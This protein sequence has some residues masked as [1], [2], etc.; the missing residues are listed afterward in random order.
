MTSRQ[1]SRSSRRWILVALLV[2]LLCLVLWI[3]AA[4][5]LNIAFAESLPF[6]LG[7]RSR[8]AANYA[9]DEFVGSLGVFRLS[10][11]D[12]VLLDRGIPP[13]EVEEQSEKI[14]E[15]MSLPVPTAT[16]RDF[17]GNEPF[18][19]TPTEPLI[20]SITAIS[21]ETPTPT[22]TLWIFNTATDTKVPPTD[23]PAVPSKTPTF[24]PSPT[25]SSTPSLTPSITPSPTQCYVDPFIV[26][27]DPPN[28][29]ETYVDGQFLPAQAFA[30]DPDN[31]DPVTC[32]PIGVYPSD[33]GV[34]IN[35]VE[36]QIE[37]VDGGGVIVYE[38]TEN[39]PA[40]CGFSGDSPCTT[41]PVSSSNWPFGGDPINAGLHKLMARAEDDGG[42]WSDW[43]YVYFILD[44]APTP[45]PTFTPSNTPTFTPT[46]TD[47]STP[48]PTHTPTNTPTF[49]PPPT[50]TPTPTP[51]STP[52]PTFT[53]SPTYTETQ[54]PTPT[55][56]PTATSTPTLTTCTAGTV[57][58]PSSGD[59]WI[60]GT[61]SGTNHGF[62]SNLHVRPT[63]GSDHRTLIQFELTAIPSTCTT[64]TNATLRI[65]QKDDYDQ[66][67]EVFRIVQPW[68]EST[69][70][71]DTAPNYSLVVRANFPG[72]VAVPTIR[73]I[74]VTTLVQ[75]WVSGTYI[76]YGFL[77]KS[78]TGS[79][80]IQFASRDSSNPHPELV[81][82]Y[83]P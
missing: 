44:L 47:T 64:V 51:S 9:P 3:A 40:Y 13:E 61:A 19:A 30:Y 25:V 71:W 5:I 59:A 57:T 15:A 38:R 21:T 62:D 31:V 29:W 24:G 79:G 34:G 53:P 82:V 8:L 76:N 54:T 23:T 83:G 35:R 33:D 63:G 22:N 10:I 32:Q 27:R 43:E 49:T 68:S 28:D 48:T 7:L 4:F 65:Y 16:A 11:I 26:I 6:S 67:I 2:F 70:T 58:I 37:W 18:T 52:S 55:E 75:E 66:N 42:N 41:H 1:E 20:A 14:K 45:T 60:D 77:L 73:D 50:D 78:N 69:V 12:E 46:Y 81:V 39:N 17:K 36:F 56:S 72:S 74:D 80:D